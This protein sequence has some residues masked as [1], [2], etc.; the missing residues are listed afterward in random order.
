MSIKSSNLPDGVEDITSVEALELEGLKRS[1]LDYYQS[2]NFQLTYPSLIEF[3]DTIGGDQNESIKDSAFTFSDDLSNNE[4]IIRPDISQ[5]IAR[6]DQAEDTK[7]ETRYCY[8]GEVLKKRKDSFSRSRI[9]V[10]AGVEIFGGNDNKFEILKLLSDSMDIGNL[11]DL[12]LSYGKTEILEDVLEPLNLNREES[13]SLNKIIS[14]KSSSD[15]SSWLTKHKMNKNVVDKLLT[16][17][18]CNGD[19]SVISTLK[20]IETDE[21]IVNEL[22][23]IWSFI[24]KETSFKPHIDVT[25]FPGFNY[26]KGLVFSAHS[27]KLGFSIANGGSYFSQT[28]SGSTRIAIGFDQDIIAMTKLKA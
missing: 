13:Y 10:K 19:L 23:E 2:E 27:E 3:A 8:V 5:Q 18:E 24:E 4:L 20:A 14:S 22:E 16:L 11:K 21:K 15:L 9:T 26:H 7:G 25:D 6:I 1:L 17:L 12:T 28:A